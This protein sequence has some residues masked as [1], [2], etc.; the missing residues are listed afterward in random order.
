MPTAIFFHSV[1]EFHLP[2]HLKT[3]RRGSSNSRLHDFWF[4]NNPLATLPPLRARNPNMKRLF[5]GPRLLRWNDG[6][7][8]AIRQMEELGCATII[9]F[10]A[11]DGKLTVYRATVREP[12]N[13]MV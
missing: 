10:W 1:F 8:T 6:K 11:F 2:R 4:R 5:I 13:K 3:S 7:V 12:F 9:F